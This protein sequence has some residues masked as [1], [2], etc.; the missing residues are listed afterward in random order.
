MKINKSLVV[1]ATLT[2]GSVGWFL[3]SKEKRN[4]LHN[5]K[6]G[7]VTKFKKR[8]AE[9]LPVEKG[10]HPDPHNIE[11]NS[12]VSEGAMTSVQYYNEKKQD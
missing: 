1:G 10:G 4:H 9:D 5:M 12:M 7:L 11:D 2:A 8:K 3:S 6:Q